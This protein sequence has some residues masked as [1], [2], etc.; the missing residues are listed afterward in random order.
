[1]AFTGKEGNPIKLDKAR[2]WVSNYREKNGK[3]A[4]Y[5]EFFGCDMINQILSQQNSDG[6]CK[7]I[8]IYYSIDD[9]GKPHLLLV[10]ATEN[11]Q[12]MLPSDSQQALREGGGEEPIIGDD[13]FPWPP[14][15]SGGG[16]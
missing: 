4:V 10:G 7:G 13:G 14:P 9:E 3:E 6:H 5:A 8:R 15:M 16:L 2:K 12:N 1:M 11:E